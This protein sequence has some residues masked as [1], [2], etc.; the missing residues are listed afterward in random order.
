M[1][2][3]LIWQTLLLVKIMSNLNDNSVAW[4]FS[5]YSVCVCMYG[6]RWQLESEEEEGRLVTSRASSSNTWHDTSIRY[7]CYLETIRAITRWLT[8]ALIS[9]PYGKCLTAQIS[10]STDRMFSDQL[11][12]SVSVCGLWLGTRRIAWYESG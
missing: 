4:I 2:F 12:E 9:A 6:C 7:N 5:G 10:E 1:H 3:L 11:V 8:A